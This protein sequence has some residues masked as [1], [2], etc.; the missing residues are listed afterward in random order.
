MPSLSL[1]SKLILWLLVPLALILAGNSHMTR[2]TARHMANVAYDRTLQASA[3]SIAEGV[4]VEEGRATIH[5]PSAA[6]EMFDYQFQDHVYYAVRGPDHQLLAGYGD[7]PR[8]PRAGKMYGLVFY[9]ADYRGEPT[10]FSTLRRALFD[11]GPDASVEVIVGETMSSRESLA[12]QITRDAISSQLWLIGGTLLL[13]ITG[14][15]FGLKPMMRL[16]DTL[17]NRN[18]NELSPLPLDRLPGELRPLVDA[19]N[20]TMARLTRQRDARKR[21]VADASHQLRT[22]LALIQTEIELT[23]RQS[24]PEGIRA[25]VERVHRATRQ[26]IHLANQL[27]SLSRAEPGYVAQLRF[28]TVDLLPLLREWTAD[29]VPAARRKQQ[30]LGFEGDGACLIHGNTLLLHELLSN[31]VDNAI[32]YT[33]EQGQITVSVQASDANITVQVRDSGPGIPPSERQRVFE[34]FYRLPDAQAEGCGLGL[35]IVREC[36]DAH[37]AQIRLEDAPSGGLLVTVLFPALNPVLA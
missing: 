37:R 24:D 19:L 4:R 16:R 22:P 2:L 14:V 8:P 15:H 29:M 6:L 18:E 9:E 26:A 12:D 27:L 31:L 30:D 5:I 11:L 10:R 7:L 23:L 1:R 3:L 35:T 28:D 32:R 21:F 36:T 34:R 17:L 25:G 20:Q 33:P 13:V